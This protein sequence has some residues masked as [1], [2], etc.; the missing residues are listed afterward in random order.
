MTEYFQR[1]VAAN[2][3][4]NVVLSLESSEVNKSNLWVAMLMRR[5]GLHFT[6]VVADPK[7]VPSCHF[8]KPTIVLVTDDMAYSGTQMFEYTEWPKRISANQFYFAAVPFLGHAAHETFFK[9]KRKEGLLQDCEPYC[10]IIKDWASDWKDG[11]CGIFEDPEIKK[12][13]G[14]GTLAAMQKTCLLYF[15]HK[16]ADNYSTL[17]KIIVSGPIYKADK[18]SVVYFGS[19]LSNGEGKPQPGTIFKGAHF[20]GSD[21]GWTFCPR[22]F[23]KTITWTYNGTALDPEKWVVRLLASL[24]A[25]DA[26]SN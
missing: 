24:S 9:A 1:F 4:E 26:M 3:C 6:H 23:Y 25:S 18:K 8:T 17:H 10:E 14:T 19:L 15:D 5:F 20:E 21:T 11:S 22:S 2:Q 7:E 12:V 13:L 16:V